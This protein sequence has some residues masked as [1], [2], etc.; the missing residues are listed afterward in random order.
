MCICCIHCQSCFV[1]VVLYHNPNHDIYFLFVLLCFVVVISLDP[2]G[3]MWDI[4]P[5]SPG[6]TPLQV[7]QPL[8][9]V[10]TTTSIKSLKTQRNTNRVDISWHLI[11]QLTVGHLI[12]MYFDCYSDIF[13]FFFNTFTYHRR[14]KLFGVCSK[15]PYMYYKSITTNGVRQ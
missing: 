3:F 4:Y 11:I 7:M 13:F 14:F 10:C 1:P 5:Y 15:L 6:G 2:I 8:E 12:W 9:D